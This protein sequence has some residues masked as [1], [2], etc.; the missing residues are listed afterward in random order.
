MQLLSA[1]EMLVCKPT[2]TTPLYAVTTCSEQFG[3]KSLWQKISRVVFVMS[4]NGDG[5]RVKIYRI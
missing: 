2:P 1:R 5:I 4:T 3:F